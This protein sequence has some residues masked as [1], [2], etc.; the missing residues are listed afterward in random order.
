MGLA[1]YE[2]F[3]RDILNKNKEFYKINGFDKVYSFLKKLISNEFNI[4]DLE[5]VTQK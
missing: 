3:N 4:N 1:I 5:E 2:I